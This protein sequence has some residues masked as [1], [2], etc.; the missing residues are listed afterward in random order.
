MRQTEEQK[1]KKRRKRSSGDYT[2]DRIYGNMPN[3]PSEMDKTTALTHKRGYTTT[4][5]KKSSAVKSKRSSVNYTGDSLSS[6]Q[7]KI[8]GVNTHEAVKND[9]K[10]LQK[11]LKAMI[12]KLLKE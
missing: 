4:L 10:I 7:V 1:R 2:T 3:Y 5:I 11:N 9:G 6:R 8:P 12:S